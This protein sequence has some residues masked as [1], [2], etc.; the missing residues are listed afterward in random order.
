MAFAGV[1]PFRAKA[2]MDGKIIE[3]GTTF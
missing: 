3:Q 1:E 2:I